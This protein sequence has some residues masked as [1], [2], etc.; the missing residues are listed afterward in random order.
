MLAAAAVLLYFGRGTGFYFDDWSFVQWRRAHTL[1]SFLGPHNEHL[2]LWTAALYK[3]LFATVGLSSYLPYRLAAIAMHLICAGLVFAFARARVGQWAALAAAGAV[4]FLGRG[5]EDVLFPVNFGVLVSLAAG[6]GAMLALDRAGP[7]PDLAAAALLT[8]SVT[9]S[10]YG[11]PLVA[12]ALVEV[13]L[14]P[15]WRRRLWVPAVP[16]AVYVLWQLAYSP[17]SAVRASN[18][19]KVPQHVA[20]AAAAAAAG[21]AGLAPAWGVPL[22]IGLAILVVSQVLPPG[23]LGPR[24]AWLLVALLGFWVLAGLARA[25]LGEPGA[26][27]YVYPAGVL[28]IVLLV[29]LGRGLH[30]SGR[31]LALLGA[32]AATAAVSGVD[33]FREGGAFLRDRTQTVYAQLTA[34]EI[35][36]GR[37]APGFA[38]NP[39]LAA[40]L[41]A[42]PYLGAVDE[43]GSPTT[44]EA[45]LVRSRPPLR[46]AADDTLV[47]GMR[48]ALAPVSRL[49]AAGAPPGVAGTTGGKAAA[50]GSCVRLRPAGG[51]Q[52]AELQ[53]P[54]GGI[55]IRATGRPV[56]VT[57]RRFAAS[58]AAKPV[59]TVAPGSEAILKIPADH[60]RTPWVARLSTASPTEAC[61]LVP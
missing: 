59:G 50:A 10:S 35:A 2:F 27:R 60:G 9:G 18:L 48:L 11:V 22:A 4:L 37:I 57:L 20:D 34:I 14:R 15:G 23:G 28:M 26:S 40:G 41:F 42:G 39:D 1:D 38:V 3:T 33:D 13:L 30:L 24:L 32:A 49:M 19:V 16:V 56:D 17:P 58:D 61:G 6:V 21:V 47:E 29:E 45:D 54:V 43:L 7:R 5:W 46:I 31:A 51:R 12:G 8:V 52:A 36:R 25:H 44:S 55:G 53:L